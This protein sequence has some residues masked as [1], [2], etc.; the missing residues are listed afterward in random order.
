MEDY[1]RNSGY[2]VNLSQAIGRFILAGRDLTRFSGFTQRVSN[3][4]E[5]L[6]SVNDGVY[7][8]TMVGEGTGRV[9]AAAD[10]KGTRII[11]PGMIKFEKVPVITPNGDVLVKELDLCVKPGMNTLVTGPNGYVFMLLWLGVVN[12]VYSVYSVISGHCLMES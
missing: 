1:S 9:V 12:L 4:F 10:Q 2:L 8:R 7:V 11:E 5:T 3:F 6:E